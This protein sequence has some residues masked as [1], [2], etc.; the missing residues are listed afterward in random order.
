[1]AH[2]ACTMSWLCYP[3]WLLLTHT[4]LF[5]ALCVLSCQTMKEPI[6]MAALL[7]PV[8][9][10]VHSSLLFVLILSI[11]CGCVMQ[12]VRVFMQLLEDKSKD[13]HNFLKT[14]TQGYELNFSKG[15]LLMRTRTN[16]FRTPI[17]V[18]HKILDVAYLSQDW[19]KIQCKRRVQK[20]LLQNLRT[21][22]L[23]VSVCA[24]LPFATLHLRFSGL[25]PPTSQ[26]F[27]FHTGCFFMPIVEV[28]WVTNS[29]L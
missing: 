23:S 18:M 3:M 22:S 13:V 28:R 9:V 20:S 17:W 19:P 4:F 11:Q 8:R 26:F 10:C 12:Y 16:Q 7:W 29:V 21:L 25:D 24:N 5:T 27:V 6:G 15:S 14:L 2:G 1:M